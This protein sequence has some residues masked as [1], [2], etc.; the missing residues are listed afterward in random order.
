MK[1]ILL[2]IA[3]VLV[4][5]T[6]GVLFAGC[7][8]SATPSAAWAD[9]ETLVYSITQTKTKESMGNMTVKTVRSPSDKSLN[10]KEYSSADGR[11]TID[12]EKTGA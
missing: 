9:E 2:I 7:S 3:L 12:V 4:T 5:V 1:K 6:V 10:G 11:V 8:G